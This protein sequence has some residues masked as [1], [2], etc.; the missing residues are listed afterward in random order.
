MSFPSEEQTESARLHALHQLDLLDTAPQQEFDDLVELASALCGTPV[1]LVTLIDAERQWIM[2]KVGMNVCETPRDISICTHAIRQQGLFVVPDLAQDPRFTSNPFVIDAPYV[3]FYAGVPLITPEGH[4][5]GTLCVLDQVPRELTPEQGRALEALG[6]QVATLLE[7]HHN[8]RRSERNMAERANV[9]A[10]LR[11]SEE[12][13]GL[14]LASVGMAMWDWDIR[15]NGFTCSKDFPSVF[16][17]TDDQWRPSRATIFDWIHPEDRERAVDAFQRALTEGRGYSIEMRGFWPDGSLHWLASTTEVHCDGAG[18]TVRLVGVIQDITERRQ[19]EEARRNSQ[20]MLRL[21][22]DNIPQLVYWKDTDSVY[23][24]CNQ[25]FAKAAG[26]GSPDE[27]VGKTDYEMNWTE[28]QSD[29]YRADDRAVMASGQENLHIIETQRQPDGRLTWTETGKI[30]IKNASGEVIGVLGTYEDITYRLESEDALRRSEQLLRTVVTS[31]PVILFATDENGIFTLSEGR[32]LEALG[33]RAGEAVGSDAFELFHDSPETIARMRQALMGES[34]SC[35]TP[36]GELMFDSWFSPIR[37]GN[38]AVTGMVGVSCDISQRAQAERELRGSEAR[39]YAFMDNSPALTYVKDDAGRYVFANRTFEEAYGLTPP[40]YLGR[41][42]LDIMSPDAGP[43][44]HEETMQALANEGA[45]ETLTHAPTAEGDRDWRVHRFTFRDGMGRKFLG[46]V[47]FDVTEQQKIEHKVWEA[48]HEREE[49]WIY[50]EHQT[51]LLQGQTLELLQARDQ[52]LASMRAKSDF[53]ANM[54]HEIRT[55]MNGILG[56]I[57]LLARTSLTPQQQHYAQTIQHSADSLLTIINDIL[58]FSKIEAGKMTIEAVAFDLRETIEEIIDLLAPRAHEKGLVL[59]CVI[60]PECPQHLIGDGVRI[61]QILTNLVGN[62]VKFTTT[63]EVILEARLRSETPSQAQIELIVRDTGVG[64]PRERQGVIFD[65]FTQADGG[66]TRQFGGSGL[67]LTICRQL[68]TLMGGEIGVDS[69]PGRGS[70][71]WVTL[72]LD[73]DTQSFPEESRTPPA[74]VGLRVLVT[75]GHTVSRDALCAQF[76][77]WGCHAEGA[78][79][80]LECLEALIS[81]SAIGKPFGLL[82]LDIQTLEGSGDGLAARIAQHAAR[83]GTRSILIGCTEPPERLW[84]GPL[85][86][87]LNKPIRQSALFN[88]LLP[89]VGP[90]GQPAEPSQA[91]SDETVLAGMTVLLAEDNEINQEVAVATLEMWGCRVDVVGN[92][93]EALAALQTQ[94][95]DAVLMDVQMPEMDGLQATAQIRQD[96]ADSGR[97]QPIIAMTAHNMRGDRE[98]C[99]AAGMDDYAA[100]P[101]DRVHL[102]A[103]LQRWRPVASETRPA[104]VLPT[105]VPLPPPDLQVSGTAII[106]DWDS[107]H[108]ICSGKASLERRVMGEFL[109]LLPSVME[110]LQGAVRSGDATQITFESHTLKGSSRTLGAT[111]LADACSDLEAAAKQEDLTTAV[112]MAMRIEEE[113][114]RLRPVIETALL[115]DRWKEA[116]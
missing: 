12:R 8:R 115:E 1:A 27:I 85:E 104:P 84:S 78:G 42:A 80:S 74:F 9:Q 109:R 18:K 70:T 36:I 93:R 3:R 110:R 52:A 44:V 91:A 75:D 17:I 72:K 116:A 5:L 108:R 49:A 6:R 64:V 13:L 57:G 82:L 38:G 79:D 54:S 66:I 20:E 114:I 16:G 90:I 60:P 11:A 105:L 58:D 67:G 41:T 45:T 2:A 22:I 76:R 56:M 65:S 21:I 88:T 25:N 69:E 111:A 59:A 77:S 113:A 103:A 39:F 46:C 14:A 15:D 29:A 51:E 62:A 92:G 26:V 40:Q 55:P 43:R 35:V 71:F 107:L 102:L 28:A 63:G 30:P 87:C 50:A 61:R 68:T 96:E 47:A 34:F 95:Y 86:G 89:C 24:G 48:L 101:I 31:A 97:H 99:L 73:K 81:A 32:G 94:T 37:D 23:T 112:A 4:A 100:K 83:G 98:S 7:L 10:A 33:L 106:L 19:A 53:L